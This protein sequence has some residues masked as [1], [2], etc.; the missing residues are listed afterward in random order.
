MQEKNAKKMMTAGQVE[1][2]ARLFGI[3]AD[4]SRLQLLKALMGGEKTVG[5]LVGASGLGQAN[6]SKHLSVLRAGRF[7]QSRKLGNFVLYSLADP[8]VEKLCELMCGRMAREARRL[9]KELV[10]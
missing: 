7:V 1:E 6:V 3:L 8:T 9:S 5:E 10:A 2:A 4:S